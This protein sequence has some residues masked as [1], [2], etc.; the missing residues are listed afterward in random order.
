MKRSGSWRHWQSEGR[1]SPKSAPHPE[2]WTGRH[3]ANGSRGKRAAV[4]EWVGSG[5]HEIAGAGRPN[6]LMM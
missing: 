2:T 5:T 4:C 6:L 1:S 3:S